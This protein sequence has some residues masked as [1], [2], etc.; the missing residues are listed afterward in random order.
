MAIIKSLSRNFFLM[1]NYD[2]LVDLKMHALMFE[3]LAGGL[4]FHCEF[5]VLFAETLKLFRSLCQILIRR[6]TPFSF[7]LLIY[8]SIINSLILNQNVFNW[9][10]LPI[11]PWTSV[12]NSLTKCSKGWLRTASA[13][14]ALWHFSLKILLNICCLKCVLVIINMPHI[15]NFYVL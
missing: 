12:G 14:K 2:F 13:V 15:T 3:H 8:Y 10:Y 6:D 5:D 4:S 7:P 9:F 11:M 1:I